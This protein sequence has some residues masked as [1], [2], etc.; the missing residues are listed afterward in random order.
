M[1]KVYPLLFVATLMLL[2]CT[3]TIYE[4]VIKYVDRPVPGPT[5]FVETSRTEEC[6][7]TDTAKVEIILPDA[8]V[9]GQQVKD[10]L[11]AVTKA[12]H[13]KITIKGKVAVPHKLVEVHDSIPY[14]VH[15]SIPYPVYVDRPVPVLTPGPT[16]YKDTT[17]YE[18]RIEYLA[19]EYVYLF[20]G[21]SVFSV[22]EP[23]MQYYTSFI[24]DAQARGKAPTGGDLIVQYVK[25][26]DLP[27]ENWV[28]GSVQMS[29][30]QNVIYLDEGLLV[31][32]SKAALYRELSRLELK[33]QY[34]NDV[35]KIMSPL[36]SVTRQIT[37]NDLNILFQ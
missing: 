16:V 12:C 36:F 10:T 22:P 20:P 5:Q 26:E 14:A 1:K 15:D 19:T 13:I 21:Q 18:T 23:L 8:I 37:T 31:E 7:T 28:S 25:S 11:L 30:W 34:S 4:E 32:H 3:E 35:N 33:K 9:N 2:G 24:Q 29:G 27:G 6:V 17:I